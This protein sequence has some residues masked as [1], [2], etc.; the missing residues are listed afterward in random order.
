[1]P[2]VFIGPTEIVD[3]GDIKIG[4]TDVQEIYVGATKIWPSGGPTD[5]TI[6]FEWAP[7]SG[8]PLP[9][10][11]TLTRASVAWQFTGTAWAQVGSGVVRDS[12]RESAGKPKGFISEP[13]AI[14]QNSKSNLAN[15]TNW[16][17][18]AG[19]L[20]A[21]N[22][23]TNSLGLTQYTLDAT[24]GDGPHVRSAVGASTTGGSFYTIHKQGT[25]RYSMNSRG[26]VQ[27]NYNISDLQLGTITEEGV[28]L[29]D[30]GF[31]LLLDDGWYMTY[32]E[33]GASTDSMR[34]GIANDPT[35]G[36]GNDSFLGA[37]ETILNCHIQKEDTRFPTTPITPADGSAGTRQAEIL[38]VG[39]A[40][41]TAFTAVLSVTLPRVVGLS[42]ET[43]S[44]L[45][46][47]T[48]ATDILRVDDTFA[49]IMDDGGTPVAAGTF[50]GGTEVKI[51]YGR[52]ATGRSI[53]VN[54]GA[55][56]PGDAPSGAH[57]GE[58]FLLG[59]TAGANQSRCI[60]HEV[61]LYN[62]RKSDVDLVS[63][64]AP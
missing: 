50:A 55:V 8:D 13:L 31:I 5:P 14:N 28:D 12:H 27:T 11:A 9:A 6:T 32:M 21:T 33:N 40:S 45:G 17:Q 25:G 20:T 58:N 54:G 38:N 35:P 22:D 43:V 2:G 16:T 41:T 15:N 18:G 34:V 52:D 26:I 57:I 29:G 39:V 46:P 62:E 53:S 59:A 19:G 48:T 64:S 44:L 23:G 56:T 63:L 49:L 42:G 30:L 1:M 61:T 47:A 24:T 7:V 10:G 4:S 37:N 3:V 36:Q 51:A 60:H